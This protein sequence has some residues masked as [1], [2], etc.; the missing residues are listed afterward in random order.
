MISIPFTIKIWPPFL[1]FVDVLLV[2]GLLVD[3]LDF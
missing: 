1:I 2:C 3:N